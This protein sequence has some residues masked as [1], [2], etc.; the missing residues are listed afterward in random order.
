MK[1]APQECGFNLWSIA[2]DAKGLVKVMNALT[3]LVKA[4]T[5]AL[6]A[7]EPLA[8]YAVLV[9]SLYGWPPF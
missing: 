8:R 6:K 3:K 2:M 9:L 7:A 4:V 1:P 5:E